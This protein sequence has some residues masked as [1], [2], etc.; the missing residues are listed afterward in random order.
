MRHQRCV[1]APLVDLT[2][3]GDRSA[4]KSRWRE[5][6]S[7]ERER[8]EVTIVRS[9]RREINGDKSVHVQILVCVFSEKRV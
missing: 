8:E 6:E 3:R 1:R 9:V 5:T 7:A 2:V 4:R